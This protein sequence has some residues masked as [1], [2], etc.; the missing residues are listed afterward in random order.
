VKPRL[1]FLG[2]GWIGRHRLQATVE[3]GMAELVAIADPSPARRAA[4]LEVVPDAIAYEGLGRLL[5]MPLDGIV[6]ATPSAMHAEQA[7]AA[8]ARGFAVFCQ[9]PLGRTAAETAHVVESARAADRLVGVDLSYRHTRAAQAVRKVIE[10]GD[11]GRIYALDL[12]FHNAYGP[13]GEWCYDRARSGGGCVIDLGVHLVDLALWLL[14]FPP[15]RAVESLLF[16]GGIRLPPRAP[17]V[18]DFAH[19]QLELEGGT[20]IRIAC[21]WHLAAGRDAVIEA[22]VHGTAGGVALR[23]VGGSFYD[24]VAEQYR[25]AHSERLADPPDA[26]GGRAITSWVEALRATPRFDRAAERYVDVA[27]VLDAVYTGEL[28]TTARNAR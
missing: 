15:V 7:L 14:G 28:A 6:I 20:G 18:E 9:K 26:W 10:R 27:R 5:E 23:N 16:A 17:D 2:V 25:G 8:L 12:V 4:A 1:G 21:S 24:F 22:T 3:H 13:D 11:L 19:V